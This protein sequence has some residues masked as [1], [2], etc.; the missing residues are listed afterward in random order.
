MRN[1]NVVIVLSRLLLYSKT[2]CLCNTVDCCCYH[3]WSL[4]IGDEEEEKE[5]K[6]KIQHILNWTIAYPQFLS[7][8]RRWLADVVILLWF[9]F[10]LLLCRLCT[11]KFRAVFATL[12]TH[13]TTR[14]REWKANKQITWAETTWSSER[15]K[16]KQKTSEKIM[17]WMPWKCILLLRLF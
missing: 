12:D 6:P 7:H 11:W 9:F 14:Q 8:I 2:G 17:F 10:T 16:E 5:N 1:K 3:R 4:M 15:E 13:Q